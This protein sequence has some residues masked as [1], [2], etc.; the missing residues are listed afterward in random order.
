MIA[1]PFVVNALLN[2]AIGLLVAKFL[3]PTE[4]GYYAFAA[5]IAITL[6]TLG[7]EWIRLSATRFYSETDRETH[8][9]I[10]ATLNAA[11]VFVAALAALAMLAIVIFRFRGPLPASLMALT[12]GLAIATGLFDFSAALLRARFLDQAYAVFIIAKNILSILLAV[13]GAWYCR[14][15]AAALAG[16]IL[17]VV[18]S[19]AL[20]EKVLRDPKASSRM[21]HRQLAMR[22]AGYG[23]PLVISTMLYQ[24]VPMMNRGLVAHVHNY[25]EAGK[26]SLA[27]DVGVRIISSIGSAADV[28]LFQLA[29]RAEKTGGAA[30]ARSFI[31][32]NMGIVFAIVAPVVAGCWLIMPSFERLLVPEPFRGAFG[33]YFTL[34][35]PA[36]L[37]F[38]LT[39]F[40]LA[41]AF[42]IAH[43]TLPLI[44][45]ALAAVIANVLAILLLPASR[46]ATTFALAQ[47]ISSCVG[48]LTT[49]GFL[50]ILEPMW[51]RI[52]DIGS[53]IAATAVM[54]LAVLPLR[55]MQ[56]G[57]LTLLMQIGIGVGAYGLIAVLLDVGGIRKSLTT[58]QIS[59]VDNQY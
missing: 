8:P 40:A 3:G 39:N 54:A 21:A 19:Y 48:F 33:Y 52:R 47:S 1:L 10:R 4:F 12:V 51:P 27:F 41:P 56:P 46:D 23:L 29:V 57:I 13:G 11:F 37:C 43:R 28:L 24:I 25:A 5:S 18:G 53:A 22:Y 55:A 49:L 32:R 15:A 44:I 30:A 26:Y 35:L 6:A 45:C 38:G 14:S 31:S 59:H 36:I 9:E 16:T 17:S 50:L 2:F 42:Q 7:F 20:S 58:G 34:M